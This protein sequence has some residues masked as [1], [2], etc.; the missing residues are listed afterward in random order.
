MSEE[1]LFTL[2]VVGGEFHWHLMGRGLGM[3]LIIPQHTG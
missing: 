2:G 3:V 1:M